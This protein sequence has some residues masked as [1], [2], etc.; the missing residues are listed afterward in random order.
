MVVSEAELEPAVDDMVSEMEALLG[1]R[2]GAAPAAELILEFVLPLE[3]LSSPVEQWRRRSPF[4]GP[5]EPMALDHPIVLRSLDRHRNASSHWVWRR[6]WEVLK[7]R[8]GSV[9]AFWS[10]P[11]GQPDY[12]LQL[13]AEIT[14]DENIVSLVLSE[15]LRA[16]NHRAVQEWGVALKH[17]VPAIVWHRDD[18]A[19]DRVHRVVTELCA[20]GELANLPHRLAALRRA[21]LR[22]PTMPPPEHYPA[23][24]LAVLW[25]DPERLPESPWTREIA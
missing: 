21:A 24:N 23:A 13:A 3:F 9:T 12:L 22:Q 11:N 7:R 16:E 6:R 18:C 1:A 25:D 5:D 17:G 2:P 20:D 4:G 15:P 19:D 14:S 10:R 8:P